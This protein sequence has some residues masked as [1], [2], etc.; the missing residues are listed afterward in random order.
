VDTNRSA[1][2][3]FLDSVSVDELFVRVVP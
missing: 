1:G 2:G 3:Q